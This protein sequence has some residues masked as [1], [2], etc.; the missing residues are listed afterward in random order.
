MN[1]ALLA[2]VVAVTALSAIPASAGDADFTLVNGTGYEIREVYISP[3]NKNSW[4]RDRLGDGS[5]PNNSS[6][7]F[8]FSDKAN[9]EQDIKVVFTV[10]DAEVVWEDVDLCSLNKVTLKYNKK[11][12][13]VTA[14]GE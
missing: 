8:K 13:E 14:I 10:E 1:K 11:T 3:A 5:L 4:G 7:L 6:K 12:R 2:S 9:C